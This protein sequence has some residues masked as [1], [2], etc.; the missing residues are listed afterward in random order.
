MSHV[1]TDATNDSV[2]AQLARFEAEERA[3]LG[4]DIQ[5]DHW[6]DSMIDPNFTAKERPH[7]TLL[8]GGLTIAHD[9]LVE[10]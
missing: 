5:P 7:T 10:G 8:V 3:R 1:F 2:E 6:T 9:F 4:L